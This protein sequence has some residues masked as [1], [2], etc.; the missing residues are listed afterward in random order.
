VGCAVGRTVGDGDGATD[1]ADVGPGVGPGL[2]DTDGAAVLDEGLSV[3][4]HVGRCVKT[5]P[6]WAL[7]GALATG[8]VGVAAVGSSDGRPVDGAGVDGT[9]DGFAVVRSAEGRAVEG[10]KVEGAAEGRP[11]VGAADGARV[12]VV[13]GAEGDGE[14]EELGDADGAELGEE[15]GVGEGTGVGAA[16][17][18]AVGALDGEGVHGSVLH[19][20]SSVA[21]VLHDW[22]TPTG[23]DDKVRDRAL[24]PPPQATEQ[25][26][27]APQP[28]MTQSVH[29]IDEQEVMLERSGHATPPEKA[30]SIT[31]RSRSELPDAQSLLQTDHAPQLLIV[32]STGQ[33]PSP[34]HAR[35]SLVAVHNPP[36]ADAG[37]VTARVRCRCAPD[38]Q[39]TRHKLQ[40]CQALR[41]QSMGH[42]AVEQFRASPREGQATPPLLAAVSTKRKREVLPVP[43]LTVHADHACHPATEQSTGQVKGLHSVLCAVSG[44][45]VPPPVAAC[46]M[47]RVREATPPSHVRVHVVQDVHTVRTQLV[48]GVG[49]VGANEGSGVGDSVG[50]AVGASY[51]KSMP[52]PKTSAR[53]TT[54]RLSEPEPDA[55]LQR[56]VVSVL[57]TD[58]EHAT[59][60]T[61]T[62]GVDKLEPKFC[63][64]TVRVVPIAIAGLLLAVKEETTGAASKSMGSRSLAEATF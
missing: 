41:A 35:A 44:Q 3:G 31:T 42:E 36:P 8:E 13:G 39:V 57:H 4:S 50:A 28:P 10:T 15:D 29:D 56:T 40:A 26:P 43:Q 30:A 51:V 27:H 16:L 46:A 64:V 53:T 21:V 60:A 54:N 48:D 19:G 33:A 20:A 38:P 61:A 34:A 49:V 11:V 47:T 6:I 24:V 23:R 32:Q 9:A 12:M 52:V 17:G 25:L 2:G 18:R 45:G 55:A 1:G 14:G 62:D 22:A 7:R 63:P 37:D 58:V 59:P 5:S